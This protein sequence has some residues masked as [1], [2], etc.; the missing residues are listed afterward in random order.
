MIATFTSEQQDLWDQLVDGFVGFR[1]SYFPNENTLY[2]T[3][4]T[5]L[6]DALDNA[7]GLFGSRCA[8]ADGQQRP[9]LC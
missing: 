3:A 1:T 6:Q 9:D 2:A 8:G 5:W 4:E 7:H